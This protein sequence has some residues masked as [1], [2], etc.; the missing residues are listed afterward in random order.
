MYKRTAKMLGLM[1]D[2]RVSTGMQ[3]QLQNF[4]LLYQ[5]SH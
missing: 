3:W 4:P 2:F 1:D 5:S